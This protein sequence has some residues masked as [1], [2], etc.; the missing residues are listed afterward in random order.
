M[1]LR[2]GLEKEA[3]EK[4][5]KSRGD[6]DKESRGD[7]AQS[8]RDEPRVKGMYIIQQYVELKPNYDPFLGLSFASSSPSRAAGDCPDS[9][10]DDGRPAGKST[11][12]AQQLNI[13]RHAW[14]V[15]IFCDQ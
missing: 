2:G 14:L 3:K 4:E 7:L 5:S 13:T 15:K 8:W 9:E 1:E 12:N 6:R 11:G 10:Q